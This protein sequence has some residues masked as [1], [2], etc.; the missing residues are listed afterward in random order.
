[1]P[2]RE[3]VIGDI[4]RCMSI[5]SDC[6]EN[7]PCGR[8]GATTVVCNSLLKDIIILLQNEGIEPIESTHEQK[9]FADRIGIAVSD[10]WCGACHF[11]LIGHPKYC[12]NC[13]KKVKWEGD[14]DE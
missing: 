8:C 12:P 9:K 5:V 14:S 6:D 7:G 10:F 11:N 1:M 2:D 13:G 3:K 4:K